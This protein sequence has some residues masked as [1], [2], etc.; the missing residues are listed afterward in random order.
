MYRN[1]ETLLVN[2]AKKKEYTEEFK[3]KILAF[4]SDDFNEAELQAQLQIF[5]ESFKVSN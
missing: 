3:K 4:Y 2:A 5:G 1:L